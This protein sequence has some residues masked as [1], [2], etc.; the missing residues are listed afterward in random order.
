MAKPQR[1]LLYYD[2]SREAKTALHFAANLAL[3]LDAHTDIL[4][5][6]QTD[7]VIAASTG[8]LTDMTFIAVRDATLTVLQEALDHMTDN[9]I[10]AHGHMTYGDVASSISRHVD[11]LS[12]DMLVVGHRTRS[13]LARWL[14]WGLAPV[15][16][17]D[18]CNGLP[19]VTIACD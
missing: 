19:L 9:R 18:R 6:A 5:V 1:I 10:S 7:S 3:A 4:A 2:G 8:Y 12:A 15:E 13:T 14:G 11:L 16:L 17:I